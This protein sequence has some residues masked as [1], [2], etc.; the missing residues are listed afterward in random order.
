MSDVTMVHPITIAAGKDWLKKVVWVVAFLLSI[1]FALLAW[2]LPARS[3]FKSG[4]ES[5]GRLRG[6]DI[7]IFPCGTLYTIGSVVLSSG[8]MKRM[9]PWPR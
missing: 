7:A 2:A 9:R 4:V 1:A 5:T 6:F 3:Q 8:S